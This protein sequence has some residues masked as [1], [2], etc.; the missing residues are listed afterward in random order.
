MQACREVSNIFNGTSV[1]MI[2]ETN[3]D[4]K[5]IFWFLAS[6]IAHVMDIVNIRTTIVNYDN[7]ERSVRKL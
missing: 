6:D 1:S 7:D 5:K 2:E 3:E 4:G